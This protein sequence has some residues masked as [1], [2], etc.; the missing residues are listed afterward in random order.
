MFI[1]ANFGRVC[2]TLLLAT[3]LIMGTL[4]CGGGGGAKTTDGFG[5]APEV[6]TVSLTAGAGYEVSVSAQAALALATLYFATGENESH[7]LEGKSDSFRS[8]R[9]NPLSYLKVTGKSGD[10]WFFDNQGQL[11]PDGYQPTFDFAGDKGASLLEVVS[12]TLTVV[13]SDTMC[14][15]KVA[16]NDDTVQTFTTQS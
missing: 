7:P 3:V 11:L 4:G 9:D 16:Y 10:Y 2:A 13:A 12:T 15:V 1:P 6:P 8:A 5:N 14:E